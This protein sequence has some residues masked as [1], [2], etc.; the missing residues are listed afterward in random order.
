[1]IS[2]CS[3][4]MSCEII[5][6]HL[7]TNVFALLSGLCLISCFIFAEAL[8]TTVCASFLWSDTCCF[9][10]WSTQSF[11]FNCMVSVRIERYGRQPIVGDLVMEGQAQGDDGL[12]A[13]EDDAL[14]GMQVLGMSVSMSRW[15]VYD[16]P[17]CL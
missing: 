10:T 5:I 1:M 17:T 8:P 3:I 16:D 7:F 12:D 9:L 11:I 15:N 2:H 6:V 14:R 4:K 13:A